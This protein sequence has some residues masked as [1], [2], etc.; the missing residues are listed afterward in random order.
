MQQPQIEQ[1]VTQCMIF[2]LTGHSE[3]PGN[4]KTIIVCIAHQALVIVVHSAIA[5]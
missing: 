1:G 2:V 3:L 4:K 5:G